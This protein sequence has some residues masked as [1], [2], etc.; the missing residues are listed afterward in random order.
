[1]EAEK[2]FREFVAPLNGHNARSLIV[3]RF[4]RSFYAEPRNA[5]VVDIL[6]E[7]TEEDATKILR[8]IEDF[9]FA[10][11]SPTEKDFLEMEQV[12]QPGAA[13][14]MIATLTSFKGLDFR[15]F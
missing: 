15:D 10:D 13:P 11:I 5:R 1:M 12:I 7:K 4:A 14:L 8:A 3:R 6:I 2:D 9:G